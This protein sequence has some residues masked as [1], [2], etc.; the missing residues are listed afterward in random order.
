MEKRTCPKSYLCFNNLLNLEL[1]LYKHYDICPVSF[2]RFF[3][4]FLFKHIYNIYKNLHEVQHSQWQIYRARHGYMVGC[5]SWHGYVPSR[6]QVAWW[7]FQQ[8]SFGNHAVHNRVTFS[9][10]E[11]YLWRFLSISSR[12]GWNPLRRS[13][14][15][16]LCNPDIYV[17]IS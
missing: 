13:I 10:P 6:H 17:L 2:A 15:T 16:M 4:F 7:C 5:T 8:F 14:S 11:H 1:T 12:E 3:S 9:E